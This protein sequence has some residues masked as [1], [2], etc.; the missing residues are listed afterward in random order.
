MNRIAFRSLVALA[1]GAVMLA[2]AVACGGADDDAG[3]GAIVVQDELTISMTDHKFAPANITI[4]VGKSVTI[5]VT[6]DGAAVH[7][8]RVLSEKR[9]GKNF[10]SDP[11]IQPGKSDTFTVQFSKTGTYVFQCDYH[12]PD[13]VGKIIVK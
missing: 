6:N 4:P 11:L 1:A 9:E 5:T 13:M 3:N 7:N 2:G 10:Q 12:L 8:M